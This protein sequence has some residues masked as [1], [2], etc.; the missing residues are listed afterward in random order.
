MI[1]KGGGVMKL[2]PPELEV[3]CVDRGIR[4]LGKSEQQLRADLQRWLTDSKKGVTIWERWLAL[5]TS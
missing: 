5:P 4:V 3:A 1:A 2:S